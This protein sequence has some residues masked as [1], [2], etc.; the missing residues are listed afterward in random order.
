V[1]GHWPEAPLLNVLVLLA[2]AL[3]G[4]LTGLALTRR[5]LLR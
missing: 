4:F 2:F 1:L 3:T 5:R